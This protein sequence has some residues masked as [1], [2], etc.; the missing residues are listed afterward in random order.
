MDRKLNA[1]GMAI[2]YPEQAL[3]KEGPDAAPALKAVVTAYRSGEEVTEPMRTLLK[4]HPYLNEW[5]RKVLEDEGL[6]PPHAREAVK[7]GID[8][9]VP[10]LGV[11]VPTVE[12]YVCPTDGFIW[13]RLTAAEPVPPCPFSSDALER[14]NRA[15]PDGTL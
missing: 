4:A 15:A 1:V 13:Y 10:L 2:T 9:L 6:R 14:D 7:R 8:P 12:R 11:P 3:A 5:V